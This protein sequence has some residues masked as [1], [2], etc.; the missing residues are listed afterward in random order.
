M[1]ERAKKVI[2]IDNSDKMVEFGAE[3]AKKHGI[4]NLE[5]RLGDL[6]D[7]PIRSGS[8]DLAFLSQALHHATHPEKAVAEAWRILK[9]GGRVAVLDLNR[10]QFE[11]SREMYAAQWL[12]FTEAEVARY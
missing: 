2:A 1:A 9:P 11:E 4:T 6:E 5:Y 8:V 7:V 10:H 3:L 12:G